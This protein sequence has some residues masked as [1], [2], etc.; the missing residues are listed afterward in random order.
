MNEPLKKHIEQAILPRY[1]HFDRAHGPEHARTVIE[2]SLA[3]ARHY[4]VD[5]Q[6]V[7]AIAA[8][9]DVGLEKGR[10]MHHIH[11]GEILA[12]DAKL[13]QWFSPQQIAVMREAV[14][15][16]RASSD[17]EPRTIYGRI[18]AEADRCI[19]PP[20]IVRRTIQYGLA[21]YPELDR[22]DQYRRCVDHLTHK[23]AE[24][25]YLR[26]WI[27][28]SDN[29]L[30]LARLR[31]DPQPPRAPAAFRRNIRPGDS[32][33]RLKNRAPFT[34]AFPGFIKSELLLS[35]TRYRLRPDAQI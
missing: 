27:P 22:E 35:I 18:V 5:R 13:R 21:N 25:G 14:E 32:C 30:R 20:T 23:Y 31:A 6:M 17:H 28:E 12:A 33:E 1:E 3:L 9:H 34:D 29:A 24:G 11:S 4:Q 26:L 7:Y 10:E 8:Y 16:H 19:D 15:D 2:Q